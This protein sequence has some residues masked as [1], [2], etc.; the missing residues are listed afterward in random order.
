M[1]AIAFDFKPGFVDS[2]CSEGRNKTTCFTWDARKE[3]NQRSCY[4]FK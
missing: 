2:S 1:I 3:E 4:I